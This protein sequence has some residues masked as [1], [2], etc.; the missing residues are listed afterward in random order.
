MKRCPECLFIYP[1]SD[2]RCDFDQAA[3]IVVTDS[4]IDSA[5]KPRR[6][7]LKLLLIPVAV[8]ILGVVAL[9]LFNAGRKTDQTHASTNVPVPVV[10]ETPAPPAPS[11][12]P[13]VSSSPA[14]S[15]TLT[16]SPTRVAPSPPTP[17][18]YPVSPS[19]PAIGTRRGSQP[20][21][22]LS[23]GAKIDAEEVWRR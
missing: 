22:L 14:P 21:I 20:T 6:K 16:P 23:S 8:V 1:E 10:A 2:E 7:N 11:P 12:S 17:S 15:R 5:T 9:L 3:L 19:G 18:V 13:S 4:E